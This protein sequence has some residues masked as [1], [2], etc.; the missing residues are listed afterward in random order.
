M[1][2]THRTDTGVAMASD[3][4]ENTIHPSAFIGDGVEMGTGISVGPMAVIVGPTRIGDGVWIGA[5]TQIG[6]PP[7]I[8]SERHN[9]AWTGDLDHQ[10]VVIEDGAHLRELVVIHQGTTRPTVIGANSWLLNRAYVAHD[11][12]LGEQVTLSAGVSVGGRC[13]IRR[14]T[15][16]GMNASVHQ[17]SNIGA[18]SMIGMGTPVSRDIPPF[19]KAYGTPIRVN[20]VNDFGMRR[21]GLNETTIEAIRTSYASGDL[22]VDPAAVETGIFA[23]ELTWWSQVENRNPASVS[24]R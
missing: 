9:L 24:T 5:G 10:G 22:D 11:V 1:T 19:A 15:N 21:S 20:D 6:G 14:Q 3:T 7:E 12:V 18:L 17:R 4:T 8:T 2:A 13:N 23:E 16:I